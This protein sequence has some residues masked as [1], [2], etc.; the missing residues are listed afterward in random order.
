[1]IS[2]EKMHRLEC[3]KTKKFDHPLS[4]VFSGSKRQHTYLSPGRQETSREGVLCRHYEQISNHKI[5]CA[6]F[7]GPELGNRVPSAT[8]EFFGVNATLLSFSALVLCFQISCSDIGFAFGPALRK[9]GRI[10]SQLKK[11]VIC[12][13]SQLQSFLFERNVLSLIINRPLSSSRKGIR[14][15]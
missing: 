10:V 14:C 15:L 4:I 12:R 8:A 13:T 6:S 3:K 11:K 9:R 7:I 5:L 1:M 2:L